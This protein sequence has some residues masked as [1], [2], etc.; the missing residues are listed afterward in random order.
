MDE[1]TK[2]KVSWEWA[3]QCETGRHED[4]KHSVFHA[5]KE[6]PKS[7]CIGLFPWRK[8]QRFCGCDVEAA[9]A[10]RTPRRLHG[11]KRRRFRRLLWLR[12]GVQMAFK[13][14]ESTNALGSRRAA[15]AARVPSGILQS[16]HQP[17]SDAN[18]SLYLLDTPEMYHAV[19]YSM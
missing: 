2:G 12:T 7:V 14:F 1:R 19:R 9:A 10:A 18:D 13:Y 17:L 6:Q 11:D 15:G 8:S 5:H 16:S 3:A 4:E